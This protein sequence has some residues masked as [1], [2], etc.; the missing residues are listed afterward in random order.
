MVTTWYG[1][2]S[3]NL[4]LPTASRVSV[5]EKGCARVTGTAGEYGQNSEVRSGSSPWTRPSA[6][7]CGATLK[8]LASERFSLDLRWRPSEDGSGVAID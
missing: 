3:P 7:E 1:D 4:S 6:P 2:D 5:A 8:A